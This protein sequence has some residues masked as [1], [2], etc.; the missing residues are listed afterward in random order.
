MIYGRPL[1]RRR[2]RAGRGRQVTQVLGRGGMGLVFAAR[3]RELDAQVALTFL[4][5]SLREP[6]EL[7]AL[8]GRSAHGPAPRERARRAGP[9]RRRGGGAPFIVM[10]CRTGDDLSK[11]IAARGRLPV[12]E[13]VDL[14]LQACEATADARN[15]GIVHRDLEP[16]HVFVTAGSDEQ[17]FVK[18]D[19][20]ISKSAAHPSVTASAAVVGSPL[21]LSPEPL[22]AGRSVGPRSDVWALGVILYEMLA[23]TTPFT[24]GSVA[25]ISAAILHGA[26]PRLSTLRADVP[27]EID[28]AIDDALQVDPHRHIRFQGAVSRHVGTGGAVADKKKVA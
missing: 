28:E 3:H 1:V 13:A 6:R 7:R 18:L 16:A 10:E 15:L 27:R 8:C 24:G 4:L 26:Y 9:R 21:Y 12:A 22:A 17:A 20:G 14:R 25:L 5:P 11:V 2:A 19:F 23:G